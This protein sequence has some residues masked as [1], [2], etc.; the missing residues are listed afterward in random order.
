LRAQIQI[1]HGTRRKW[2]RKKLLIILG[3]QKQH[4]SRELNYSTRDP[5][6]EF[7]NCIALKENGVKKVVDHLRP[8]A[9]EQ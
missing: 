3:Q 6:I 9:G 8:A 1:P 5:R 4:G 2:Q 7:S